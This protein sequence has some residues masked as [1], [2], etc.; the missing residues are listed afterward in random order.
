MDLKF[1]LPKHG[2]KQQSEQ[3]TCVSANVLFLTAPVTADGYNVT[4]SCSMAARKSSKQDF[5]NQNLTAQLI[6]PAGSYCIT[7]LYFIIIMLY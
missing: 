3:V 7:L 2:W 4:H 1:E 5:L 6:I